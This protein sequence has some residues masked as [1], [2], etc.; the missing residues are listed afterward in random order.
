MYDAIKYLIVD[1]DDLDRLT[2]VHEASKYAFMQLVAVCSSGQEAIDCVNRYHPDVVFS[3]I[4]MPGTNGVDLVR[5]LTGKIPVPVFITSH[6][7][8]ALESYDL[9]IFDYLLKPLSAER[10]EKCIHRIQDFFRLRKRAMNVEDNPEDSGYIVVKQGYEKHRLHHSDIVYLESM[11]DYT[12]IR[13]LSG[14]SLLV[15]ETLSS[16]LQQLP[17]GRFIRIH[18]S[19]AI[20]Q[21]KVETISSNRVTIQGNDLP[22]GKSYRSAMNSWQI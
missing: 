5:S 9:Q 19:Y 21:A 8:F 15:L 12:K 18:R 11:K 22:I 13:T 17:E 3:D 16:L 20:N 1:D 6:P 14:H 4:E 7:E 2:V 10:F